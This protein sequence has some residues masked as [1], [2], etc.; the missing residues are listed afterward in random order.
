MKRL[1]PFCLWM[2]LLGVPLPDARAASADDQYL[3]IYGM[4]EEA[5]RLGGSSQPR[6]AV[7]KYL[8]AQA[9]L[10]R[11]QTEQPDWKSK[12]ITYRLCYIAQKLDALTQKLT[13]AVAATPPLTPG[14]LLAHQIQQLQEETTRLAAQNSLLEAKLKEALTVQPAAMD[15]RELS[16]AEDRIKLLQK[17]RD[18]LAVTL[19]QARAA[20]YAE[21]GPQKELGE[22]K[23]RLIQ[24]TAV[25]DVLQR[26][27]EELQMQL[28]EVSNRVKKPGQTAE[29]FE[30]TL[31]YRETIAMLAASNSVLQ[32][33]TTGMEDRLV[34]WVRRYNVETVTKQKDYEQKLALKQKEH[35]QQLAAAQK[36]R[37]DLTAKLIEVTRE[38]SKRI[39]EPPP[40][41]AVS[42]AELEKQLEGIRAKLSIFEAKQVP[43]TVEELALFKQPNTKLARVETNTPPVAVASPPAPVTAAT[44]TG[45]TN[46][47]TVV[48][49]K[50]PRELPPGAGPLIAEA[51]RAIDGD[52][53]AD[54]EARYQEVLRQDQDNVYVLA[55]LAAVQV[56][57]GKT[58]EAEANL[59][60]ALK[61]APE[62]S[63]SL[64]MMGN[65]K[66]QQEKYDEAI[67]L[68][69]LSAKI[70]PEKALTQ[71]FL[72]KALIQ[73]GNRAPAET[74]LRRAVQ[75]KPNWGEPH[76]LLSVLYSTQQPNFPELA[77][78]HYKK[79]IAGG[80]PRNMEFER[81][82]ERPASAAKP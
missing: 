45:S 32:A 16:K 3:E 71:F 27:N 67:E 63:A 10:R 7:T 47:A 18:L 56:D 55:N 39:A 53:F 59:A 82:M 52:R 6:A 68:L 76:Y 70:N 48:K 33:E 49:K 79:A 43:F 41:P 1:L 26:Q 28:R 50:D 8:E 21:P 19:E 57:Q 15:P 62:D 4:L 38:L 65:L 30:S 12:I 11:L 13:P 23:Q 36:D 20:A 22:I 25:A 24:Q 51:Q 44:D 81:W 75:L 31:A 80:A 74:A 37:E 61:V 34:G 60:H 64:Y 58:A 66:L 17:E 78:Y 5:D 40:A 77:Q 35:E 73:K 9:G 46:A 2:L 29:A 69:S 14:Q 54:A 42:T 72:G